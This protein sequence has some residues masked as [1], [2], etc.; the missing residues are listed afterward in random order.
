MTHMR[1]P[2]PRS[3]SA[4]FAREGQARATLTVL[5]AENAAALPCVWR[6]VSSN[7]VCSRQGPHIRGREYVSEREAVSLQRGD[8]QVSY[9]HSYEHQA[10]LINRALNPMISSK[11]RAS[12]AVHSVQ[13][14]HS[15][16][17]F[18]AYASS[19]S[20]WAASASQAE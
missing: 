15:S 20:N 9:F 13:R 16:T 11:E 14:R 7:D 17:N 2:R 6:Y 8:A 1:G 12:V 3:G 19:V 4:R 18:E 5:H 10:R